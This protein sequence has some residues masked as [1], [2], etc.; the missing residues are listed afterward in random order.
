MKKLILLASLM[1]LLVSCNQP[2]KEK[3]APGPIAFENADTTVRDGL[4]IHL[5]HGYDDVNRSSMALSL[6]VKMADSVDVL[7]FCDLEAVKLLTKTAEH[8]AMAADHYM[9]PKDALD[10]LRRL[11]VRIMACPMCMK[12]AGIKA[13][14]LVDGVI[15]ARRDLFF[16]FTKGRIVTLDY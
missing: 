11:N 12:A 14:D 6:A 7:V 10:E 8:P 3:G 15:V 9:C 13:E 5:S 1:A 4:F 16:G 2:P